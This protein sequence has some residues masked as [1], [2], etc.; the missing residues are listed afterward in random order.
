MGA[1]DGTV[2]SWGDDDWDA[3]RLNDGRAHRAE[4]LIGESAAPPT[5]DND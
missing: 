2:R 1:L 4:Q 5:A 3:A